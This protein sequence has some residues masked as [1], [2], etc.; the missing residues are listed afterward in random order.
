MNAPVVY[1]NLMTPRSGS[2]LI[3]LLI[4]Y[5]LKAKYKQCQNLKNYFNIYHYNMFFEK[6]FNKEGTYIGKQNHLNFVNNKNLYREEAVLIDGYANLIYNSNIIGNE[7][8]R[9]YLKETHW[10]LSRI[11]KSKSDIIYCFK[12]HAFSELNSV[13]K[14]AIKNNWHI[15][16]T[17]R[18]PFEQ[19]L[20]YFVSL[21]GQIWAFFEI[22]ENDIKKKLPA[23]K[24]IFVEKEKMLQFLN[25]ITFYHKIK[26]QFKNKIVIEYEKIKKIS[27][28]SDCFSLLGF[29]DWHQYLN[30]DT[31]K[32]EL[33]VKIPFGNLENYFL[34][35][36]DLKSEYETWKMKNPIL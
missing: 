35:I 14:Y 28:I 26:N 13:Y 23:T 2:T 8:K 27:A 18:D 12:L 21:E 15:I 7:P 32:H 10:R 5:Y 3:Q 20:E 29:N 33:P 6:L 11:N 36:D 4:Y 24:S 31:I 19:V 16:C 25:R 9:D 22:S 34:N 17:E 1:A 30:I